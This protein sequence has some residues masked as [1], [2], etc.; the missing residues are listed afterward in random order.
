LDL[1]L[2]AKK[3]EAHKEKLAKGVEAK[4]RKL[5]ESHKS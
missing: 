5:K 3:L 1:A 4:S 2:I